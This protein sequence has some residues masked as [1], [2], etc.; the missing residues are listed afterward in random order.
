M[1][2]N[3]EEDI[4]ILENLRK[5]LG[6]SANGNKIKIGFAIENILADRERLKKENL[7]MET[8]VAENVYFGS[9]P[10]DQMRQL[11]S[12]AN[13]YDSLVEKIKNKLKELKVPILIYGGRGNGRTYAQT[14]KQAKIWI[15][16]ELLKEGEQNG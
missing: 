14:E 9:M 15:L 2:N 3:I 4:K 7:E 13:K 12:K 8:E 6:L 5:E 1:S 11:Q 10:L 16:K